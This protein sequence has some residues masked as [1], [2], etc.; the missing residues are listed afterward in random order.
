RNLFWATSRNIYAEE[1]AQSGDAI[2]SRI[3]KAAKIFA[4]FSFSN[5]SFFIKRIFCL[6][7][8][9]VFCARAAE[10]WCDVPA[11]ACVEAFPR[12][13]F[14]GYCCLAL[15]HRGLGFG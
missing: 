3:K 2:S 11:F 5:Q 13:S 8:A 6:A 9:G 14:A 12:R 10:R 4:A 15:R 1:L 7:R